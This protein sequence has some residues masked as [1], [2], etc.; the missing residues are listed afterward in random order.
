MW[1]AQTL[2]SSVA[3]IKAARP[4]NFA[5]RYSIEQTTYY[6]TQYGWLPFILT[7]A[8]HIIATTVFITNHKTRF[9][10]TIGS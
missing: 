7:P 4:K 1:E 2:K 3:F 6:K 8:S 5:L 10:V 9:F